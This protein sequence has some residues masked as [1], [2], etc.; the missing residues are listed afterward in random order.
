MVESFDIQNLLQTGYFTT[1][2]AKSPKQY[3]RPYLLYNMVFTDSQRVVGRR[4]HSSNQTH[5]MSSVMSPVMS[6][7]MNLVKNLRVLTLNHL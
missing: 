6:P 1:S 5:I 2:R 4:H 7:V 3:A